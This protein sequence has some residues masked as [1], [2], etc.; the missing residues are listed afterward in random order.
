MLSTIAESKFNVIIIDD[1]TLETY[2]CYSNIN[3]T[4]KSIH[5]LLNQK[6]IGKR[7]RYWIMIVSACL[8]VFYN[9]YIFVS[10]QYHSCN[11]KR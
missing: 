9:I 2:L 11:L 3:R 6:T 10:K 4:S 8:H 7:V 5:S 1:F